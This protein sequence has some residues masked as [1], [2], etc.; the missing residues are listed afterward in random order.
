MMYVS[1]IS[2]FDHLQQNP[3]TSFYQ[4][5]VFVNWLSFFCRI[6]KFLFRGHVVTNLNN[7]RSIDFSIYLHIVMKKLQK[8]FWFVATCFLKKILLFQCCYLALFF[9][10]SCDEN[11]R[12]FPCAKAFNI[13][14]ETKN[15]LYVHL[16]KNARIYLSKKQY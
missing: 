8:K 5:R 11:V 10:S 6:Q 3:N 13:S 14:Y 4:C 2:F 15:N 16:Q 1:T 9:L 7:W 12:F